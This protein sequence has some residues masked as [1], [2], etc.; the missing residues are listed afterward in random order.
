MVVDGHAFTFRKLKDIILYN[1]IGIILNDTHSIATVERAFLDMIYLFLNYCFDNLQP[2][3]F[4]Q[5]FAWA[6]NYNNQQLVKRLNKYY[7]SHVK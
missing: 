7:N 2:I 5:C 3:N 1:P 6:M 4:S